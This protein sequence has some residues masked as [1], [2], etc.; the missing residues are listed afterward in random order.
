V[1]IGHSDKVFTKLHFN[2]NYSAVF[3]IEYSLLV[4]FFKSSDWFSRYVYASADRVCGLSHS[5]PKILH[6]TEN[7]GKE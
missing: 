6:V 1:L 4:N 5:Y 3:L 2:K 7:V